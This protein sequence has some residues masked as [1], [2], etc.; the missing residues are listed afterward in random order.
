MVGNAPDLATA[1]A[2]DEKFRGQTYMR[3]AKSVGTRRRRPVKDR[4]SQSEVQAIDTSAGDGA[5]ISH[6][7]VGE[8]VAAILKVAGQALLERVAG[9]AHDEVVPIV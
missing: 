9:H 2:A 6:G 3:S 1:C 4:L 7:R 8:T 5:G